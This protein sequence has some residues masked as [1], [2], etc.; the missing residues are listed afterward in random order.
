M[1]KSQTFI[2]VKSNLDDVLKQF[3]QLT[4]QMKG[5]ALAR[6]MRRTGE[7][8]RTIMTREVRKDYNVAAR[9]IKAT[10][11]IRRNSVGNTIGIILE[12]KGRRLPFGYFAPKQ[13][14]VGTTVKIKKARKMIPSAFLTTLQ[15]KQAVAKREGKSRL[16]IQQLYTIS[17]PEM[18]SAKSVNEAVLKA[19]G[20]ELSPRIL[21]ELNY[22]LLRAT[23]KVPAPRA[24]R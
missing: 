24:Y 19:I 7:R 3:D 4:T 20:E 17:I 22:Q 1:A 13:N 14:A 21:A 11:R 8:S 12:S 23:S 9:D 6:A 18:L 15:S 10:I 16:P 5:K 2:T